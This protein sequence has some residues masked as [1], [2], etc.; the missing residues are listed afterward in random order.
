MLDF[1]VLD[2]L[3]RGSGLLS[4]GSNLNLNR[5]NYGES[6]R[7]MP[8]EL[9]FGKEAAGDLGAMAVGDNKFSDE[10]DEETNKL[11]QKHAN[12]ISSLRRKK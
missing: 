8:L 5:Q 2:K 6:G 7:M 9:M 4:E 11:K 3:S 12:E 10:K 1:L